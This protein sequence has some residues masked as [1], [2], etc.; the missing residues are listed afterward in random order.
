MY[1]LSKYLK[2]GII[3]SLFIFGIFISINLSDNAGGVNAVETN[4]S[5]LLGSNNLGS[6]EKIGPFGN[7]SSNIKIAYIIGVHPLEYQSHSALFEAMINNDNGLK[8]CYYIY[9]VHVTKD[10]GNYAKSRANGQKLAHDFVVPDV[11]KQKYNLVI[12]VHSNR[13]N[14]A[15]KRFVFAPN[16][17]KASK[18]IALKI[19]SK[20]GWLSYSFPKSQTSPKYVTVPIMKS[21]IKTIIFENYMYQPYAKTKIQALSFVKVVDNLKF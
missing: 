19:K 2:S 15:K 13:G 17:H 9:K 11:K 16:N 5:T 10:A 6:A 21:G 1:N 8:Y 4:N 20:L 14:Y 7:T 12:D 3:L 18:T